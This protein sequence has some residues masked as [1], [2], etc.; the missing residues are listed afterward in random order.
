MLVGPEI[1]S[2]VPV[3]NIGTTTGVPPASDALTLIVRLVCRSVVLRTTWATPLLS[4]V[5]APLVSGKFFGSAAAS[6][7]PVDENETGTPLTTLLLASRT[8]A[9][10]VAVFEPSE[11]SCAWLVV[12]VR[13]WAALPTVTFADPETLPVLLVTV[14]VMTVPTAGGVPSAALTA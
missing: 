10:R 12:S 5:I 13:V 2:V 11:G 9:V 7:P 8:R 3:V 14:T 4:V 6:A 1:V